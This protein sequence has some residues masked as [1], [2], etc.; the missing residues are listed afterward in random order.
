MEMRTDLSPTRIWIARGIALAADCLEIAVF[1]AFAEGFLSPLNDALD[2]FVALALT[3]TIGWH[4]AF[5]PSFIA[6]MM[7]IVSLVPTWTA[8]VFIATGMG[9]SG[10]SVPPG[11]PSRTLGPPPEP[12]AE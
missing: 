4:W 9:A 10:E 1:P 8:A 12:P 2:V 7:P 3:A 6:E 11:G 5:V